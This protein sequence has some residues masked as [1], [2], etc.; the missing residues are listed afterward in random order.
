M[1][2]YGVQAERQRVILQSTSYVHTPLMA[3]D[4]GTHI[5]TNPT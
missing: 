2:E 4:A 3:M 5:I 1:S